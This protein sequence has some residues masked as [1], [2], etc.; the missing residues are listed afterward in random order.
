MQ[1][2][3]WA[4]LLLATTTLSGALAARVQQP[5]TAFAGVLDEHPSIEYAK[6]E[7]HDRVAT[8]ARAI[9]DGRLTLTHRERGGYLHSALEALRISLDSQFL[10]FSKTGIQ[11]A[12]TSP[13]NPRALYFDD[14]VVVGYIPGARGGT[15]TTS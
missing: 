6:R 14:S 8:L 4:A 9:A 10:V 7:T 15:G 3:A 11:R 5:S 13:L 1:R 12:S 2:T